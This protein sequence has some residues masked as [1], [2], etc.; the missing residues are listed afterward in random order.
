MLTLTSSSVVREFARFAEVTVLVASAVAPLL[1]LLPL[2][3]VM[4]CQS[5]LVFLRL[6]RETEITKCDNKKSLYQSL[7]AGFCSR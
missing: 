2:L 6:A 4:C 1:T 7:L 3:D 5:P